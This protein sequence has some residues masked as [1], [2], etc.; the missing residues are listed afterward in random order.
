MYIKAQYISVNSLGII[1]NYLL[2]DFHIFD[3]QIIVFTNGQK[4]SLIFEM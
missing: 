3:K 1:H 2:Y 4:L